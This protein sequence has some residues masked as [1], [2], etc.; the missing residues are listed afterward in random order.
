MFNNQPMGALRQ[1]VFGYKLV[2]IENYNDVSFMTR[3]E[4][5]QGI[6]GIAMSQW[7]YK[8]KNNKVVVKDVRG[9]YRIIKD[10]VYIL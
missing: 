4:I 5:A 10:T 3:E 9:H 2:K 1:F 7:Y 6:K 8:N